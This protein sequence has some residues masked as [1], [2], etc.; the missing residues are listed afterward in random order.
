LTKEKGPAVLLAEAQLC[1]DCAVTLD[2][3]LVEV[4]QLPPALAH[5]FEKPAPG[6]VVLAVDAQMLRKVINALGEHGNLHFGGTGVRRVLMVLFD[7]FRFA[8]CR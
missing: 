3:L 5:H 4:S 7:D 6:V 2:V 1:D 8:L